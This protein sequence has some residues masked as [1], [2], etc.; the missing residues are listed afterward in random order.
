MTSHSLTPPSADRARLARLSLR[1]AEIGFTEDGIRESAGSGQSAEPWSFA[2][3]DASVDGSPLSVVTRL[4]CVGAPIERH[5]AQSAFAPVTLADLEALGLVEITDNVVRPLSIIRPAHGLLVASDPPSPHP[6]IVLGAVP[7]SET[8]ARLTIRTPA[9]R[10]FD[11]GTG[12]GIQAMLLA[13]HAADVTAVDINPRAL[14]LATFNAALNS[15]PNVRVREGSW[16]GP[17]EGERFDTIACNPPYVISPDS[18]FTYRD[19]GLT[20]DHVSRMVVRE[21]ARHLADGGFATVLCNWIHDGHWADAIRPWIAD[22]GCD[23]LLLHYATL[24]PVNYAMRWNTELRARDPRAFETTV[25]RWLDYFRRE[26]IEQIAFGG[27]V[28][29]RRDAAS[30][31]WARALPMTEGPTGPCSDQILRL[32]DAADFLESPR[33]Q[34]LFAQSFTL[35]NGHTVDQTLR[36]RDG[37]YAVAPAIFKCVP[38]LGLQA[39]VDARALEVLLECRGDRTLGE[40]VAA[41]AADRGEPVDAV[42]ALIAP[43]ARELVERGFMIP[44][45]VS[46]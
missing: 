29:R 43:T 5:L 19:G 17:V 42:R 45:S 46:R 14:A 2:S 10:A 20:R 7:A 21:S 16:F 36:Y 31:H 27:I 35:L 13:R 1:L 11:L 23:A 34:D 8:L 38:G 30:S 18:T 41:T 39:P 15:M 44:V 37:Q 3:R 32:F 4:F 12:C 28:L 9:A 25:R 22:T 40:L 26:G 24:D 6:D 33:G